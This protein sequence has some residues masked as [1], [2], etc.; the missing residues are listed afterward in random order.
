ME[1]K[2]CKDSKEGL[3]MEENLLEPCAQSGKEGQAFGLAV[4]M[5][6][7]MPIFHIRAAVLKS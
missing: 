6:H 3:E 4:R 7:E 5:L 1:R 2:G